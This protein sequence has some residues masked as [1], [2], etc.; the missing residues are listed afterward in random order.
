MRTVEIPNYILLSSVRQLISEGHTTT[1]RVKG[2]SM[3]PFLKNGRDSVVLA[4]AAVLQEG[5]V[6]LAEFSPGKYVLHR[7]IKIDGTDLTLMGDGNTK[8]TEKCSAGDVAGTVITFIRNGK[9][10]DCNNIKWKIYSKIWLALFPLRRYLLGIYRLK[11][12]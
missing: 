10:I 9:N 7:I 12:A 6:V 2:N 5:D 1:I 11:K 3:Q 8:G 4:A